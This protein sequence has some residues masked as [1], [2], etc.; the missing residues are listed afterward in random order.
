MDKFRNAVLVTGCL[1]LV[2]SAAAI[3]TGS[4]FA[5][6][7]FC[8]GAVMFSAALITGRPENSTITVKRLF[9]QQVVGCFF[10]LG[11]GV[12]LFTD[13]L[14]RNSWIVT[15]TI[16]ALI[17]LYTIFRIEHEQNKDSES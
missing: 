9:A 8:T 1:L 16:G 12:L 4:I 15:L 5:K 11:T 7:L 14:G 10:L 6:Y 2:L 3:I 17:Q 13:F